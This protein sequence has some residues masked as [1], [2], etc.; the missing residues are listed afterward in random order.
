ML[1]EP[2][3]VRPAVPSDLPAL[4]AVYDSARRYMIRCGNPTQWGTD[5][6][7]ADLLAGDIAAGH[8]YAVC[9][10]GTLCAA[11]ALIAGADPTYAEI[12]GAWGS[13]APYATIHRLASDGTAP[14]VF[15][16]VLAFCL[17]RS[18][19]LRADTH[20]DNAVMQR[21]LENNG[22]RRCGIIRVSHGDGSRGERLAYE[23]LPG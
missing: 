19:H 11:F 13:E 22:F 4:L 21:L 1:P 5:Y 16:A 2:L 7:P 3:T 6:P 12:R 23:R 9:R 15:A 18:P 8:L 20:A 14:G 17:R 10:G